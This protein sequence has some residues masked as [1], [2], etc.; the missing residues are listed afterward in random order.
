MDS[1]FEICITFKCSDF[2]VKSFLS[3][4]DPILLFDQIDGFV[5]FLK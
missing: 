5:Y 1:I 2:V 3:A 4:V